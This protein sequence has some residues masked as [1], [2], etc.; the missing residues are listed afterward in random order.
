MEGVWVRSRSK[1]NGP[2]SATLFGL[3]LAFAAVSLLA[4]SARAQLNPTPEPIAPT[5]PP[6]PVAS[7]DS[8]DNLILNGTKAATWADGR[9]SIIQLTGPVSIDLSRTHLTADSAVIWVTPKANA[10]VQEQTAEIALIGNATLSQNGEIARTGETLLVNGIVR[11]SVELIASQRTAQAQRDSDVYRRARALR[12]MALVGTQPTTEESWLLQRLNPPSTGPTTSTTAPTTQRVAP[13][14][15]SFAADHVETTK[16]FDGTVAVVLTGN[17][18]LFQRRPN[19]ELYEMQAER[20]VLFTALHSLRELQ[21]STEFRSIE[22]AVRAVYLEGDVRIIH[23]PAGKKGAE[24]RL[25]ANKVYYNFETD[26]AILTEAVLHTLDPRTTTPL[27][28]RAR[29]MRQLS[30]GEYTAEA[31]EVTSSSFKTPSYSI[32]MARAYIRQIDTGDPRYGSYS[33]YNG[34]DVTFQAYHNPYFYLPYSAGTFTE[35]GALLRN[36]EIKSDNY[37]GESLITE[38]GLLETLGLIPSAN[39]SNDIS[40]LLG[41]LGN[42]GPEVG[43][44]A[45]YGDGFITSITKEP[46]AFE[47]HMNALFIDDR[48]TDQLGRGRDIVR[49][50]GDA[51]GRFEFSHQQFLPDDWQVQIQANYFSDRTFN[52]EY[53]QDEFDT[54]S[55]RQTSLYAKQQRD[56]GAFTFLVAVQPNRFVTNSDSLQENFEVERLPEIGYRRIGDSL[57]GDSLTFFSDNTL[58]ALRFHRSPYSLRELGFDPAGTPPGQP[59]LG[60]TGTISSPVY[61]GDFREEFDAPLSAGQF[62]IVPYVFGRYTGYSGSP[63]DG[64]QNRFFAGAGLKITTAFWRVDDTVS[65]DLFDLH[66]LRHVIEPEINVFT[67]TESVDRTHLFQFD[68]DVDEIN[69][70]SAVSLSLNQ[71]WQTKRGGPGRWRSVDVFTLNLQANFY[72]NKPKDELLT[73]LRF[74]G[75]FYDSLPEASIPRNSI[76]ADFTWRVSDTTAV[77]GDAQY[78]TDDRDLATA[79]IGIAARRDHRLAYFLGTRYIR[80]FDSNITT[81]AANYELTPKYTLAF[82]QSFDFG[83]KRN[84]ASSFSVIRQLDQFYISIDLHYDVVSKSSGIGIGIFPQGFIQQ[85]FSSDRLKSVFSSQ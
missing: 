38:W 20:A 66:R 43:L 52:E 49:P 32:G 73:P 74:R 65:S 29:V 64:G 33:V 10:I 60:T 19:D 11:G 35:R 59:A 25:Q 62:R 41:I 34:S 80:E 23:T 40:Y 37:F 13:L 21:K 18:K 5:D 67:S 82:R 50:P 15:I 77:L 44:K 46:W 51:R 84:V 7:S 85:G 9:V 45:K 55:P 75:L 2:S 22:D 16:S 28:M 63:N 53:Y 24:Q 12:P 76:N 17:V 58:S 79:S 47:G 8:A 68:Q 3:S 72:A 54:D 31:A 39:R 30:Q 70:I 4:L 71:R 1:A 69:D 48:G 78:N 83:I 14:P 26:Q 27:V 61:R 56:Q 36:I 57:A 81:A 42:R 6:T